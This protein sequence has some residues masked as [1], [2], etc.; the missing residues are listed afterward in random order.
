MTLRL[1]ACTLALVFLTACPPTPAEVVQATLRG[2][3]PENAGARS[4]CAHEQFKGNTCEIH[5]CDPF[6]GDTAESRA[7][8][9]MKACALLFP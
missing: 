7:V 1:F 5:A 4:R 8:D 2:L 9:A 3:S 6:M